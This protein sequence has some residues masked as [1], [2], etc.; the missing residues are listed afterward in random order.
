MHF[1]THRILCVYKTS[2]SLEKKKKAFHK[3]VYKTCSMYFGASP[4]AD[5]NAFWDFHKWL[6]MIL[7]K[8]WRTIFTDTRPPPRYK[9]P[10]IPAPTN[11]SSSLRLT[12]LYLCINWHIF[13][14][15]NTNLVQKACRK[16]ALLNNFVLEKYGFSSPACRDLPVLVTLTSHH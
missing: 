8:A 1:L 12:G 4:V 16:K 11:A 15:L 10:H 3:N 2:V 14:P 9:P 6:F 5:T 7:P 13:S